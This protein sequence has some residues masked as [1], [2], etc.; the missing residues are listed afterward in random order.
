M[1]YNQWP[2]AATQ[3]YGE[4]AYQRIHTQ[5]EKKNLLINLFVFAIAMI[6]I[7]ENL[8]TIHLFTII[9]L[10]SVVVLL[11]VATLHFCCT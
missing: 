2:S 8:K 9:S 3:T 10:V 7:K 5:S 1:E 4:A 6:L 11:F